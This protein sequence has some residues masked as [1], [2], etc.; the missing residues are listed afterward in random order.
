MT[1]TPCTAT[2]E[3]VTGRAG[4]DWAG[5][6]H[7]RAANRALMASGQR[8]DVVLI[9]D[10]LTRGWAK[11]DPQRFAG[12][13][14]N[15]GIGGQTSQQVLL[16]FGADVVALRPRAVHILVGTND[17]A[18]NTG[19][20][21]LDNTQA[22]IAAMVAIARANGIVPVL[23]TVPPASDFYWASGLP[24]GPWI[25]RLNAWLRAYARDN[26]IALADYAAVL[27]DPDGTRRPA[28]Y[29]DGAHP[30]AAGYAAMVPVFDA[31]VGSAGS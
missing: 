5:L 21:T 14:V 23:A 8:P 24:P 7:F 26:G 2:G 6:C 25:G 1:D 27:A 28:L 22:N 30:G 31:A 17:V 19:P 11:I 4:D 20:T 13:R 10:S 12:G 3:P 9:G 18:G 15:R 29:A 16:R